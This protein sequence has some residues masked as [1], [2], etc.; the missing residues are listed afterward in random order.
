MGGRHDDAAPGR[1]RRRHRDGNY[2]DSITISGNTVTAKF[3]NFIASFDNRGT[4]RWLANRS[5]L[6]PEQ[7]AELAGRRPVTWTNADLPGLGLP[8]MVRLDL[9]AR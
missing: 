1:G 4:L 2:R 5:E 8:A 6:T 9:G 7:A 3:G